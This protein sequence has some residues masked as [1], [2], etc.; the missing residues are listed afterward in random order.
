[1]KSPLPENKLLKQLVQQ[2]ISLGEYIEGLFDLADKKD[3]NY[4]YQN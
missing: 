3:N 1:M 2:E 4:Y